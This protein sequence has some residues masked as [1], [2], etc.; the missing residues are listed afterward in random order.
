M[1]N[2]FLLIALAILSMGLFV[3]SNFRAEDETQPDAQPE[4][5]PQA[6]TAVGRISVIHGDVTTMHGDG[7]QWVPATVNTP[8]VPG[9]SVATAD[10]SRAEVQLDFANVMRLDQR[11]EAKVADLEQNKI[12]I[13]L[14]SGLVDFS[15]LN[16]TQADAEIDTPNMGV[17]PLAPGV[18]RIQVNSPSE[19]LLIVRQGEAEVLTNQGSTKVEAG[20]IIQIHGTD[21]PEYK[22]DPA[23]GGDELDKW[24]SDRDRQIQSAQASQHADPN[25]IGSS[26]LDAYGQ[27]SEVP[28][29]GWCWTPQVDAGW[30][31]YSAGYWGYEPYWGWTW[32]SYEPWGWAPYHSGFWFSFGGR[33]RWRPDHDHD[34]R[35]GRDGHGGW[36]GHNGHSSGNW[37]SASGNH[38]LPRGGGVS[39][40]PSANVPSFSRQAPVSVPPKLASGHPGA[41]MPSFGARSGSP[42]RVETGRLGARGPSNNWQGFSRGNQSGRWPAAV[43]GPSARSQG[44]GTPAPQGSQ[45]NWQRFASGNQSGRWP[46]AVNGPSAGSQGRSGLA[47]QGNRY[48]WQRFASPSPYSSGRTGS[49]ETSLRGGWQGYS[50]QSRSYGGSSRPPL[51]L[52]RPIMRQRAPSGYYGGGRGYSSPWGASRGKAAPSGGSG[53][54]TSAPRSGGGGGNHSSGGGGGHS[55]GGGHG[56]GRR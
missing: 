47:T 16:G 53:H 19:T 37:G 35:G 36:D 2:R 9:D 49:G 26:D 54:S 23:P 10:R 15:V 28:D 40:R 27:W 4:A 25:Y 1:K 45:Y 46:A 33:W 22:I 21:N 56:G 42:G 8:V 6:Q 5:Q 14:A 3:T 31:P 30:V 34:G 39:G 43:N 50:S 7:G 29:Q 52:N 24:C 20:Q 44:R 51:N 11:T 48:S 12:Q 32:I 18:Y 55:T 38:F 41:N 17:H 13:Q